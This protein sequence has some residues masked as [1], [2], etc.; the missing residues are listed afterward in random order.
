LGPVAPGAPENVTARADG[1][2]IVLDVVAP[3]DSGGAP[4]TGYR[5]LTIP[6]GLVFFIDRLADG[7]SYRVTTLQA[8]IGYQFQVRAINAAGMSTSYALSNT[9]AIPLPTATPAP[10]PTLAAAP[11]DAPGVEPTP[12]A[13]PTRQPTPTRT[14]QPAATPSP[15]P[16]AT[17]QPS[18]TPVTQAGPAQGPDV[19]T[20]GLDKGWNLVSFQVLPEDLSIEN[21][22]ASI[23]GLYIE[24]NTISGDNVLVFTPGGAN[25]LT[26]IDPGHGYWIRMKSAAD[27]TVSGVRIDRSAAIEL[28]PGWNL[29]PYLIDEPWPVRLALSSIDGKYDEVRGFDGEAKSYFPVLPASFN[30][31]H[32]LEPG[33][34]YL[35]HMT[36]PAVLVYP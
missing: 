8:G 11:P 1:A 6:G 7:D 35:V 13:A 28:Q 30:T 36:E 10:L 29:V 31:L 23:N 32:E 21:V 3:A 15:V 5:V 2:S 33:E 17:A 12:A 25:T 18:N 26:G 16:T 14:P 20:I 22:L 4:V 27:L 24:V 19:A 9:V 34:G